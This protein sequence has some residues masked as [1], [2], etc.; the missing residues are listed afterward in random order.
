MGFG[1]GMRSSLDFILGV[2]DDETVML[3]M[4]DTNFQTVRYW[5][6]RAMNWH[7]LGGYII[8]RS[9]PGCYHVVFDRRVTWAENMRVVAWVAQLSGNEGLQR[10]HRM[11]CIK[12]AS[13]L[14]VSPK[15]EKPSPRIVRRDGTQE[16]MIHE[17][18]ENRNEAKT[19]ITHI[20]EQTCSREVNNI[21]CI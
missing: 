1:S 9:S 19:V 7:N 8:L 12:M 3:D 17:F 20:I 6:N 13:T 10:W 15:G 14:R 11:Q 16:G 2:S 18:L 21:D 4:D 5:A